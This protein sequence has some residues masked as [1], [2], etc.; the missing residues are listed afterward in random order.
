VL[1]RRWRSQRRASRAS[2]ACTLALTGVSEVEREHDDPFHE[3]ATSAVISDLEE[4]LRRSY[5]QVLTSHSATALG[6]SRAKRQ[7]RRENYQALFVSHT[8]RKDAVTAIWQPIFR[9]TREHRDGFL[10]DALQARKFRAH[11]IR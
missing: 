8:C 3:R 4:Q 7:A 2:V 6:P 11:R 9:V 5:Q 1:G 10:R